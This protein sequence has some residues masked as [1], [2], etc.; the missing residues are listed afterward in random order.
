MNQEKIGKFIMTCRKKKK[1]TQSALAEKLGVTDK[2]ISNWE[3]GRNMP[4]LALF[5]PLC[6]I[7][8]ISIND[9]ISGEEVSKASYQ[10][11]L[12]ENIIN[13]I[14]YSNKTLTFKNNLI[15]VLF[16]S[17]GLLIAITALTIFPSESSWGSVY[18]ILGAIF[19]LIGVAYFTKKLRLCNRILINLVFL[20]LF[21]TML[22]F[23]DYLS[24]VNIHQASRFA[25]KKVWS[26]TT[27]YYDT[28]FYDVIRCQKDTKNEYYKILKNQ[29]YDSTN[30][31]KYC[32]STEK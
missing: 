26:D 31:E 1:L 29:S 9:L 17:F 7:L 22:I 18:S 8:D 2:S 12:E 15:G 20:I 10:E 16:L 25:I 28:P 4:D 5:K 32:V 21:I 27:I 19:S 14:D 13:T 3:N 11:K 24:V 23:I 6:E 30:I